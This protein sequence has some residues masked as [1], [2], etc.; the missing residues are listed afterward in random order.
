MFDQERQI[1]A[2]GRHRAHEGDGVV[3]GIGMRQAA[4]IFRNAA[5]IGETRDRSYV[6]ERRP[7]QQ[8]PFGLEDAGTRLAPCRCREILQHVGLLKRLVSGTKV[9]TN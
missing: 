8:Q 3:L 7:A 5:V 9:R 1:A 4:G 6:R 2:I